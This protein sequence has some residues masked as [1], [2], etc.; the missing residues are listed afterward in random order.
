MKKI[1]LL[2][3]AVA[4]LCPKD[5]NAQD[6]KGSIHFVP[7]VGVNYSDFSGDTQ[8]Y[9]EGT[10]GKVNFM[11]GARFEFQIAE[12]IDVLEQQQRILKCSVVHFLHLL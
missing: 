9:F 4:L 1:S 5:A 7:Y 10:S 3:M 12:I 2:L 8:K 11:V 6:G